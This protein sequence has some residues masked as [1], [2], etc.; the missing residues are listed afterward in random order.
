MV[1]GRYQLYEIK[2]VSNTHSQAAQQHL[3]SP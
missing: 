2:E 3:E 1:W